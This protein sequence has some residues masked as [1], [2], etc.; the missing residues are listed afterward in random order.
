MV[1]REKEFH[2]ISNHFG[3]FHNPFNNIKPETTAS[4]LVTVLYSN[5]GF[6]ADPKI[7]LLLSPNHYLPGR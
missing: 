6:T 5:I 3:F 7:R 2:Q 4:I 1:L